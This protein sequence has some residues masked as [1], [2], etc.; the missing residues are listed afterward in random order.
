MT[1]ESDSLTIVLYG[2]ARAP[3]VNEALFAELRAITARHTAGARTA[4]CYKYDQRPDCVA[5]GG[6]LYT[7]GGRK[8]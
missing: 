1:D 7:D 8:G 2:L 4:L 6:R 3:E 5:H